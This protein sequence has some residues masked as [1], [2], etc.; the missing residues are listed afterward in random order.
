MI[1]SFH[2]YARQVRKADLSYERRH[3]A[4]R[5]C[6]ER[7]HWL[8]RQKFETTYGRF[9]H[10]FRFDANTPEAAEQ[11]HQAMD[12]LEIE[13]RLFLEQLRLFEKRRNKEKMRG[14]RSPSKEAIEALYR[15]IK[16]VVPDPK[17]EKKDH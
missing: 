3:Y 4:F 16:F 17:N 1:M 8:I 7:Y 10:H 5:C 6:I 12:A 9:S 13:R 14:R 15:E 2:T 11:L